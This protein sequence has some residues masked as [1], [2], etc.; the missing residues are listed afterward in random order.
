MGEMGVG[1]LYPSHATS[2]MRTS[3][4]WEAGEVGEVVVFGPK[5]G[6][7]NLI[8]ARRSH[9]RNAAARQLADDPLRNWSLRCLRLARRDPSIRRGSGWSGTAIDNSDW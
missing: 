7:T 2:S 5:K 6:A 9:G 4:R 3:R 8:K 1:T